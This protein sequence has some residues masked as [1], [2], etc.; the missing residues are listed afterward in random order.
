MEK[1]TFF[2]NRIIRYKEIYDSHLER[3]C[4]KIVK[5]YTTYNEFMQM[6]NRKLYGYKVMV[7]DFKWF[8]IHRFI[9]I[10][11]ISILLKYK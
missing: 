10:P 3:N 8:E 11:I 1:I 6:K 7:D 9:I 5:G 2:N 4:H